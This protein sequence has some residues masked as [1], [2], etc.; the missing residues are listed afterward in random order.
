MCAG[1]D[2]HKQMLLVAGGHRSQVVVVVVVAV[3]SVAE[4][5]R[6]SPPGSKIR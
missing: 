2:P 5:I 4:A 3:F 6:L 1:C